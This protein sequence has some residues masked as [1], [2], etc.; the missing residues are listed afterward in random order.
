MMTQHALSF[1]RSRESIGW[2]TPDDA[3]CGFPFS[4]ER[5]TF[6]AA[7]VRTFQLKVVPLD[8]EFTEKIPHKR[9]SGFLIDPCITTWQLIVVPAKPALECFNR[10]RGPILSH[11]EARCIVWIPV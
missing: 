9:T 2:F 3:P 10:G 1:P 7:I 4:R 8:T 6:R 11:H 5:H